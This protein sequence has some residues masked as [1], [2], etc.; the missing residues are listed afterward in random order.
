MDA[1]QRGALRLVRFVAVAIIG[2][3]L[4]VEGLYVA[5]N[6]VRHLAIGKVHCALLT[7]PLV[8]GI[9]ILARSKAV[10]EWLSNMLD[11]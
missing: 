3:S 8:L 4:I 6:L 1:P 9:V 5:G 10:A 2:L 11:V 7:I